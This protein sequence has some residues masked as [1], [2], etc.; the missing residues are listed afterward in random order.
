MSQKMN[1]DVD[2]LI[3]RHCGSEAFV[4]QCQLLMWLCTF[5]LMLFLFWKASHM[6]VQ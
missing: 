6:E 5:F 2:E 4:R 1:R 3:A